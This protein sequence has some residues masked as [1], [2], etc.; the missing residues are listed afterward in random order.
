MF[1]FDN[2]YLGTAIAEHLAARGLEVTY[3]TTAGAA[4]AWTFMTNEQPLIHQALARRN[5]ALRTLEIV[6]GFDG[7]ARCAS[8]RSSPARH[9]TIAARSL[10]IVGQRQPAVGPV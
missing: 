2:Y 4:S 3:I 9:R 8:R 6:T 5:I 1:D 7:R 10:V